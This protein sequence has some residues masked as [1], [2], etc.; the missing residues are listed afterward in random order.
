M[1]TGNLV[2]FPNVRSPLVV[3]SWPVLEWLK[4]RTPAAD[5]FDELLRRASS[6][7]LLLMMSL[8]NLGEVYYNSAKS[9]LAE[10]PE[11]V[12][13]RM[14]RLPIHYI[15]V[16]DEAVYAAALLKATYPIA[17]ADAFA[18][19]LAVH[20]RCSLAT[21]DEDFRLLEQAGILTLDWMGA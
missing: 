5:L 16:S 11:A 3:D 14:H 4:N 17:Y 6:G 8:V 1:M 7:D 2:A 10:M 20:H 21:G 19:Q 12:L 18:A 13:T 9:T 15:S